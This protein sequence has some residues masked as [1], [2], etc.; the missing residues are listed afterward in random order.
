MLLNLS[1]N[2]SDGNLSIPVVA[3]KIFT[4]FYVV[5]LTGTPDATATVEVSIGSSIVSYFSQNS[6]FYISTGGGSAS[7]SGA[8][9]LAGFG[10][11]I[12]VNINVTGSSGSYTA[13]VSFE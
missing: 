10:S 8:V 5:I 9:W 6:L 4:K 7:F 12:D 13:L 1:R 2:I 11:S 3:D